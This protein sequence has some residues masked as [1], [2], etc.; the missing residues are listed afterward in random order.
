MTKKHAFMKNLGRRAGNIKIN[1]KQLWPKHYV[2]ENNLEYCGKS[3][4]R[5]LIDI[6]SLFLFAKFKFL[7]C[8]K[9]KPQ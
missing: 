5:N 9:N 2:S 3:K 4:T 1:E 8:A 7:W 6:V